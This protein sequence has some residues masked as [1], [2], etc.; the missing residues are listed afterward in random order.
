MCLSNGCDDIVFEE[1]L[2]TASHVELQE[3]LG[4]ERG[5]SSDGNTQSLAQGDQGLLSEIGV[6]L[7]LQDCGRDLGIFENIKD[8]RS[9]RVAIRALASFRRSSGVGVTSDQCS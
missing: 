5:I 7:N 9:L 1:E 3:A 2:S 8:Q 4:S 6:V